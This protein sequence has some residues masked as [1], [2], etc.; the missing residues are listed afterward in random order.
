MPST[1]ISALAPATAL[2]GGELL[3]GVQGGGNVAVTAAQLRDH[4][5][6]GLPP[7]IQRPSARL[8]IDGDSKR[9]EP[10]AAAYWVHARTPIDC[11]IGSR[12]LGVG[13]STTGTQATTGLTNATRMAAMQAAVAAETAGGRTVDML[14]TIGTNDVVLSSYSSE[15]VLANLRRYQDAFRAAGGRFLIV[16]A[17]DPRMGLSSATARQIV[18]LNHGYAD[19]CEAVPDAIFCDPTPWWLD[20]A[21]GNGS[22]APIG[23]SSGD[24]FA[25]AGDGLHGGAY[26]AY[27]KQF[28][29]GPILR[30][31]YR[32]RRRIMLH[33]GDAYDG[34]DAVRGNILGVAGRT[35]ATGGASNLVNSGTGTID[36]TPPSGWT[37]DGTLTGDLSIGFSTATCEPLADLTGTS[38]WPV[39]RMAFAGTPAAS[40]ALTLYRFAGLPQLAATPMLASALVSANALTGCHGLYLSTLNVS[41]SA[42]GRLG[43]SGSIAAIDELPVLDGL[44]G[45][46]QPAVPVSN[47]NSGVVIGIRWRAGV[48]LSGSVDLV[49]ACW[50]RADPIPAAA[51]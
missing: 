23:G 4:A 51:A 34:D 30:A 21:A 36:G 27:R 11:W 13:G 25:M 8:M 33:P 46:D 41:P 12:D 42:S 48:P 14:L 26:G 19:Y 9:G 40:G 44:L 39:V 3:P 37:A 47:S 18:A 1:K 20:P 38:G 22:F 31:I 7:R 28:A 24:P 32:P 5:L 17:V 49:G 16:M 6:A 15:T 10:A 45:I 29:L 2:G 43:A 50:R 35:V